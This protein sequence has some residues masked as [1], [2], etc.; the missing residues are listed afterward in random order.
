M[1]RSIDRSEDVFVE[2]PVCVIYVA[3]LKR[4]LFLSV[5]CCALQQKE[6]I[7][8]SVNCNAEFGVCLQINC[9]VTKDPR[10]HCFFN[11]DSMVLDWDS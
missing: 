1:Q 9:V 8:I 3:V 7:C 4:H 11:Y 6:Y 2:Y 10:T 5:L